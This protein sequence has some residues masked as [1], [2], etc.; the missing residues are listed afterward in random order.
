MGKTVTVRRTAVRL[1]L[2]LIACVCG[3]ICAL[4]SLVALPAGAQTGQAGQGAGTG[5]A[6][7][8]AAE[9]VLVE[10]VE[11]LAEGDSAGNMFAL[12][13]Q[14][15]QQLLRQ[16]LSQALIQL[17]PLASV[18]RL[19]QVAA[20]LS[21]QQLNR[22]LIV[23]AQAVTPQGV[24]LRAD[25]AFAAAPLRR[26]LAAAGL[27]FMAAPAAL[28]AIV[29]VPV[30]QPHSSS[31]AVVG[32]AS[33]WGQALAQAGQGSALSVLFPT[34]DAVRT[35]A[36]STD[37]IRLGAE[38]VLAALKTSALALPANAAP[39]APA[40]NTALLVVADAQVVAD[41]VRTTA[42]I[43]GLGAPRPLNV[44]VAA[45]AEDLAALTLLPAQTP[46]DAQVPALAE[47]LETVVISPTTP[48]V[49][50]AAASAP[51]AP[52][53]LSTLAARLLPAVEASVSEQKTQ[54]ALVDAA[55]KSRIFVRFTAQRP[56]VVQRTQQRLKSLKEV[57]TL[58]IKLM[59]PGDVVLEIGLFG[60]VDGFIEA[61]RQNG[62]APA[63][64]RGLWRIAP[65]QTG[66][67]GA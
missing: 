58:A 62:F 24:M 25:V 34:A 65:T 61:L 10:N 6:P 27:G 22:G 49:A 36:V 5:Q 14:A 7:V 23:R 13:S 32:Q 18:D 2:G 64:E 3:A 67:G 26:A 41:G 46:A 44:F 45:S 53:L 35:A 17:S 4:L 40:A 30:W 12:R 52:A 21:P 60:T 47:E 29:V 42:T 54:T 20:T 66:A 56:Q 43:Y 38:D 8:T 51:A 63:Q 33:P 1:R 55:N 37:L 19:Q 15:E 9:T 50:P 11:T 59:S 16:A 28:P 57:D 31:P 39:A 48:G